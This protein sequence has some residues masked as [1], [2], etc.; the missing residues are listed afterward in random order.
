MATSTI[1][2]M[3]KTE[4]IS[5]TTGND[6]YDGFNYGE[7][8]ISNPNKVIAL[9]IVGVTSNRWANVS[10]A[11]TN[12]RVWTKFANATVTVRVTSYD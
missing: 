9:T 6:T 8:A 12:I 2:K 7:K 3:L 4:D 10:I 5:V 1:K 11:G